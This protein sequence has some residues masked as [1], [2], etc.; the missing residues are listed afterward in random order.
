[1]LRWY[2]IRAKRV[3]LGRLVTVQASLKNS[4]VLLKVGVAIATVEMVIDVFNFFLM[5]NV[6]R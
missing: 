1:M 2:Q 3:A 4:D 5:V 6:K